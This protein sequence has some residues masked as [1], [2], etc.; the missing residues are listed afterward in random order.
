MSLSAYKGMWLVAMFDLPVT[1]RQ[2]RRAYAR[3]RKEL[4][5]D[6]FCMLQYSVYARYCASEEASTS[7][8]KKVKSAL[9]DEGQ[10]R[11]LTIT[12]HQF[13]KME[14]FAGVKCVETEAAPLQLEFF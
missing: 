10:V 2:Y 7:H 14:V 13:G 12:D 3:F 1:S 9:P 6:G 8:R 4:L 5:K 11:V